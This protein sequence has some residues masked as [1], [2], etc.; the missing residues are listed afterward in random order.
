[1]KMHEKIHH[2]CKVWFCLVQN[3]M[4][5]L[6]P[7]KNYSWV[8]KKDERRCF[9]GQQINKGNWR[10][11]GW[12]VCPR[13]SSWCSPRTALLHQKKNWRPHR[14]RRRWRSCPRSRTPP[15]PG[16]PWSPEKSDPVS[17]PNLVLETINYFYDYN[18]MITLAFWM[19][20]SFEENAPIRFS[21]SCPLSSTYT[22]LTSQM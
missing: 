1:M 16:P 8:K 19:A 6:F 15:P 17:I 7:M 5:A 10:S 12:S 2:I 3:Y 9:S 4:L 11:R 18:F 13:R 20:D 14:H 22:V 21:V